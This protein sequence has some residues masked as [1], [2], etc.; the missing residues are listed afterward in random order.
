MEGLRKIIE[1]L[2]R[3]N[4]GIGTWFV[5]VALTLLILMTGIILTQVFFRYV[6]DSA[7]AWTEEL[8]RFMMVW[9]AFLVAPVAH[10]TGQN[11]S[12]DFFMNKIGY[13]R[14]TCLIRLVLEVL[15]L[16]LIGFCFMESLGMIERGMR[17]RASSME[18][19][20]ATVYAILP[21][22]F[23]VMFLCGIE[24]TLKALHDFI[25]PDQPLDSMHT[26][27]DF[28]EPDEKTRREVEAELLGGV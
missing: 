1:L 28:E 7:L 16:F 9:M 12:M 5:R 15:V 13:N 4:G 20:M 19:P 27:P 3:L 6:L 24:V 18:I 2:G 23:V 17:I 11:V 22:S 14:F 8:A 25:N 10:R 26:H 21:V